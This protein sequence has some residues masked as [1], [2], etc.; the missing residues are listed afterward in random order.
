MLTQAVGLRNNMLH[1]QHK[2]NNVF[3]LNTSC[4]RAVHKR[5][6]KFFFIKIEISIWA[7]ELETSF[8]TV[9]NI[10]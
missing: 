9:H 2:S 7:D 5:H 3:S 1:L 4:I 6:A 10:I 8:T